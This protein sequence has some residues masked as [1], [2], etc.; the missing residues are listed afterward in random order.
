MIV[1]KPVKSVKAVKSDK[2]DSL[3]RLKKA[4]QLLVMERFMKDLY[5]TSLFKREADVE[6]YWNKNYSR[7][8]T[9]ILGYKYAYKHF[10]RC[11]LGGRNFECML[12]QWERISYLTKAFRDCRKLCVEMDIPTSHFKKTKDVREVSEEWF[13]SFT[14]IEEVLEVVEDNLDNMLMPK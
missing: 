9:R 4:N 6:G 14:T 8:I 10:I 11:M 2:S 12:G 5:P 7:E 3:A 1:V 13:N